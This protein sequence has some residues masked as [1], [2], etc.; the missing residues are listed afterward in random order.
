ME[1]PFERFMKDAIWEAFKGFFSGALG[2]F[3]NYRWR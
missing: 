2:F 1:T 3:N